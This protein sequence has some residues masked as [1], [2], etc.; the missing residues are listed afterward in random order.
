M[1]ANRDVQ[2]RAKVR[3]N[4]SLDAEVV[5]AASGL[6]IG[7]K[8]EPCAGMQMRHACRSTGELVAHRSDIRRPHHS[9][10]RNGLFGKFPEG[11]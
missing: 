4:A 9:R 8:G 1:V 5:D 3:P 10:T 11:L 7:L 2:R 6:R